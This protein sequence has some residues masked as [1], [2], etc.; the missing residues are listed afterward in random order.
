M[1]ALI[2]FKGKVMNEG[3]MSFLPLVVLFLV[4][5]FLIIRPQQKQ[6]KEHKDMLSALQKGDKILTNGGIFGEVV[7]VEEDHLKVRISD[8]ITI[9][10]DKSFVLKKIDN[11]ATNQDPK[12][13]KK[14]DKK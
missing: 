1:S 6:Q 5:Y 4:F 14:E 3:I 10:L 8:D 2:L 11:K 9:K 7:K 12:A 13:S